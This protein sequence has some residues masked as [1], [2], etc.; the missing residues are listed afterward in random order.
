M[1]DLIGF[2]KSLTFFVLAVWTGWKLY[3]FMHGSFRPSNQY[4]QKKYIHVKYPYQAA[5]I[6]GSKLIWAGIKAFVF[7]GEIRFFVPRE[8]LDKDDGDNN[9]K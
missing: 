2:L 7:G 9:T 8:F 6:M 5:V 3:E 1:T 4:P